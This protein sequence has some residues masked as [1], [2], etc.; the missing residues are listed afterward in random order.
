MNLVLSRKDATLKELA[1]LV[2]EVNPDAKAKD[3]KFSFRLVCHSICPH[4]HTP[5]FLSP[6]TLNSI[7]LFLQI[8]FDLDGKS[9][10][11]DLGEISNA[12]KGPDDGKSLDDVRFVI[13]D[14][15]DVAIH[16]EGKRFSAE[17]PRGGGGNRDRDDR[18][19][20]DGRDRREGSRELD[21][22]RAKDRPREYD[23]RDRDRGGRGGRNGRR[24]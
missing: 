15:V 3:I 11:K 7:F 2:K 20:R 14:F 10:S 16:K 21:W 18:D 23:H 13:G 5:P 9:K 12:S 1:G 8:F 4:T 17:R 19:G 24:R 22:E 6:L